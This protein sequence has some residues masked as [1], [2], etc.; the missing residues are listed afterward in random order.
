MIS[1]TLPFYYGDKAYIDN[2]GKLNINGIGF[3]ADGRFNIGAATLL[4]DATVTYQKSQINEFNFINADE[5]FITHEVP[6]G[7]YVAMEG[8]PINSFYGYVTDGIYN[9]NEEANGLIGPNGLA[10]GAGDVKFMDS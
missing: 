2:G 1:H 10:M 4:L 9:T 5:K 8:N 3:A 6:G 7:E